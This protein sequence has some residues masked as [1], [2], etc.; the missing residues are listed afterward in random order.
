MAGSQD[1]LSNCAVCLNEFTQ[2]E[3]SKKEQ[4]HDFCPEHRQ[5][6]ELFCKNA[7]CRKLICKICLAE[8][9]ICHVVVDSAKCEQTTILLLKKIDKELSVQ[10]KS[11]SDIVIAKEAVEKKLAG[12]LEKLIREK[13]SIMK[14]FDEKIERM[15]KKK[16]EISSHAD[17]LL[18][19]QDSKIYDLRSLWDAARK[20]ENVQDV[21]EA[22]NQFNNQMTVVSKEKSIG[23]NFTEVDGEDLTEIVEKALNEGIVQNRDYSMPEDSK[24]EGKHNSLNQFCSCS[25]FL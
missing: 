17:E 3:E 11:R 16:H 24:P 19:D 21:S 25:T 8:S 9:H 15:R 4:Q 10:E 7:T 14:K 2:T 6:L 1:D 18:A 23:F 12:T 20:P 13:H 5:K 22:L